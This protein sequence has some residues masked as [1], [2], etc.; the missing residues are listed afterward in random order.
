MR[1]MIEIS[2]DVLYAIK[3]R[4][5]PGQTYDQVLRDW[6]GLPQR[7]IQKG[8][9]RIHPYVEKPDYRTEWPF[10]YDLALNQKYDCPWPMGPNGEFDEVG[11]ARMNPGIM[12]A[13][14]RA[15]IKVITE[16][17][18]FPPIGGLRVTRIE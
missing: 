10:V 2:E 1:K 18:N 9:P 16:F 5:S 13:A 3:L 6:L 17:V 7:I 11:R 4:L 14:K 15:G 12:R 8:R